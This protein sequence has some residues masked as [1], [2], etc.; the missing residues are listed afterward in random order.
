MDFGW[1]SMVKEWLARGMIILGMLTVVAIPAANHWR[2]NQPIV[3][4]A[5]MAE[6]GGWM[7]GSLTASVG[8]PLQLRLTSDDV[9]HGFAIGLLDQAA[10]NVYPGET[11]DL[12]VVFTHPGKYT[13]Y[14]TR[15][16]GVNHWRMRGTIEVTSPPATPV[17]VKPPL[18]VALG[19][20]IDATHH[21]SVTPEQLPSAWRGALLGTALSPAYTSRDYYLSHSP[22]DFW[23][24]LRDDSSYSNLTDQEVWDLVAWAWQINT[25]SKQIQAGQELFTANC[26]ACHGLSGAGNGV[27]ANDLASGSSPGAVTEPIGEHTL[28]PADFTNP[29]TMLSASPAHLQGKIIRGGMGT[30]MPAWGA[31]FTEDQTWA[32][33]AYL[34]TFQL[35]L[36]NNP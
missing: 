32:L 12:T 22:V 35:E 13:F 11:T 16:C 8:Q 17:P 2:D 15:W 4:H 36:E 9:T 26:A 34:W 24:A 6:S 5:R 10:V 29:T 20:N 7:P 33:V 27:Y 21:A 23:L 1:V 3:I 18:Y 30:G 28:Q 31:I 14:C 19:L 25:T